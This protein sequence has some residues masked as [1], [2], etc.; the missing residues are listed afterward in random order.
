MISVDDRIESGERS[1]FQELIG[2]KLVSISHDP[3]VYTNS[4]YGV[5]GI[6]TEDAAF[7]V[8]N[9]IEVRDYYGENEDVA[10]FKV[11]KDKPENIHSLI[12]GGEMITVPVNQKITHIEVVN[13]HQRLYEDGDQTY[14][15][16]VTRGFILTL[17][18][19]LQMS[20]EKDI[21]FSEE[22][23]IER[24]YNLIDKFFS[25]ERVTEGWSELKKMVCEREVIKL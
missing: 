12:D 20:F 19:G 3:L 1:V 25:L 18:D 13:E 21:W 8:S 2:K 16:W 9:E 6:S 15:V 24:G 14:D 5:A 22:I 4:V 23:N 7:R 10:I 11:I 17:E